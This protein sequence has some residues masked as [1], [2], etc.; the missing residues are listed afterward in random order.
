MLLI[1]A[2]ALFLLLSL[3][4]LLL[5]SRGQVLLPLLSFGN[6]LA[7]FYD[8]LLSIDSLFS[9]SIHIFTNIPVVYER[10]YIIIFSYIFIV[11]LYSN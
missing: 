10:I 4:L 3:L 5:L 8:F 7:I 2:F 9:V 1:V 6:K 11:L